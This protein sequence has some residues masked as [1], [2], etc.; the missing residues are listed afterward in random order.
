M[1]KLG[2]LFFSK[3]VL[4][5]DFNQHLTPFFES[6]FDWVFILIYLTCYIFD[7]KIFVYLNIFRVIK[8]L[9]ICLIVV[10]LKFHLVLVT[11]AHYC[12]SITHLLVFVHQLI[13]TLNLCFLKIFFHK[14]HQRFLMLRRIIG[15][16]LTFF[17]DVKKY[18]T[19]S[20]LM[21][22]DA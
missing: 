13:I 17:M 3:K 1:K 15:L 21:S 8:F 18:M 14:R 20:N 16:V 11:S 12:Y 7:I 19:S 2:H 6:M 22:K 9:H 10:G 4:D 5:L